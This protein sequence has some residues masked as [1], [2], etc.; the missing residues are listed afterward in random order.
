[1]GDEI[2]CPFSNFNSATVKK[3]QNPFTV[4]FHIR[5][6]IG[7]WPNVINVAMNLPTP[8]AFGV[9]KSILMPLIK[10]GWV[11]H[12]YSLQ[13][14][15]YNSYYHT[16]TRII[17]PSSH[18]KNWGWVMHICAELILGLHP[19]NER[20]RYFLTTSLIGWAQTLNQPCMCQWQG[21]HW[22]Q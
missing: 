18:D 14:V 3:Y 12:L 7:K 13:I 15:C 1:M 20:R 11:C 22:F 2:T 9:I 17:L 16:D 19:A 21:H 6:R 5:K 4:Y 8:G 10:N